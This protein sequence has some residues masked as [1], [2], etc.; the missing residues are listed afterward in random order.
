MYQMK[1]WHC[2]EAGE[3]SSLLI[4]TGDNLRLDL[5]LRTD[6]ILHILELTIGFEA[7]VKCNAKHK[8][9]KYSTLAANLGKC[10]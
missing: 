5:F 9:V 10:C 2:V 6:N 4:T 8:E 7:N 1:Y 3:K